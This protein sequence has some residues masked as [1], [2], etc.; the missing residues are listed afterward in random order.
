MR[1]R[2]LWHAEDTRGAP[3]AHVRT[4]G[5]S[6]PLRCLALAS[7]NVMHRLHFTP[8]PRTTSRTGRRRLLMRTV[9][10]IVVAALALIAFAIVDSAGAQE[11]KEK[12]VKEQ[13]VGTWWVVSAVNEGMA[14]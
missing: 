2:T 14:R 4:D 5:G 12:T 11:M 1:R 8:C 7:N 10:K 3:A 6:K 9:C 13:I